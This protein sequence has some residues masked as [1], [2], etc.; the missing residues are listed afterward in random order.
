MTFPPDSPEHTLL[1]AFDALLHQDAD[2]L[3]AIADPESGEAIRARLLAQFSR[4]DPDLPE[5]EDIPTA[6]GI[7]QELA[8]F[9]VSQLKSTQSRLR[10]DCCRHF[11]VNEPGE[12]AGLTLS[13]LIRGQWGVM[14]NWDLTGATC[15]PLGHVPDGDL[16][17]V[18]YHL[19]W[20]DDV[21]RSE[22]TLATLRHAVTG[23]RLVLAPS[24]H[25]VIPG[26]HGFSAGR[27]ARRPRA[28]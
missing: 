22:P 14:A 24:S 21:S 6:A 9:M 7:P 26:M 23:W 12:I 25:Y 17:H 3:A 2:A 5:G 18:V 4:P 28:G 10:E 8:R 1:A 19:G 15:H 16:A 27:M 13:R 20:H 11:G